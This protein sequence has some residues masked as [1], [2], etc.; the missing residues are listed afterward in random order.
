M[1]TVPRKRYT[2]E[3]KAQAVELVAIGKPVP[4]VAEE[5]GIGTSLLYKW[6]G[7]NAPPVPPGGEGH[8]VAGEETAVA[9]LARR[10]REISH[11]KLENDIL[12]KAAIILGAKPLLPLAR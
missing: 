1:S 4:E 10:R 2:P 6:V 9:E 3:F 11:L 5:F 8:R 12:K 7:K